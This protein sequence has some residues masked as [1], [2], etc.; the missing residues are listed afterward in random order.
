MLSTSE[1]S[2]QH[3]VGAAGPATELQ[4]F[5]WD[6]GHKTDPDFNGWPDGWVRFTGAGHPRYVKIEISAHDPEF[7]KQVRQLDTGVLDVWTKVRN[8]VDIL[9]SVPPPIL[10]AMVDRYLRIQLDGGQARLTSPQIAAS[11]RYQYRF[12]CRIMTQGLRHDAA[13]A[14][15]VFLDKENREITVHPTPPVSGTKG[16]TEVT[17]D[18]IRPPVGAAKMI[19]RLVVER[20]ENGL[21]D[22]RGVIGFDDIRIDQYPQMR[23]TTD[24]ALGVY[25]YGLPIR[26]TA[27]IMGLPSGRPTVVF[28]VADQHHREITR[29]IIVAEPRRVD[30]ESEHSSTSDFHVNWTLPQLEPGF[31]HMTASI[32]GR[33]ASTLNT[34][35]TIAVIDRN[36]DGPPH[37][38]FGWS[39][40]DGHQ[41]IPPRELAA[42]LANLG[43]AW[44][45]YPCWLDGDDPA[46]MDEVATILGKLRE[47]GIQTIGLLDKPPAK[48]QV[49][50]NTQGR[51]ELLAAQM[52]H[53]VE[54]WKPLLSPV[55]NRLSLKVRTWQ[56]GSDR[57]FSFLETSHLSD[58]IRQIAIGLQGYSQPIDV[59]ISWPWLDRELPDEEASWNA[60][61]RSTDPPLEAHEMDAFL[62]IATKNSGRNGPKIWMMLDPIAEDVYD[63]E[64]RI[65]DLVLRMAT[66]RS[67][68]V[69]AAFVTDPRDP[70][71]G[72]LA[73]DGRPGEML[74]PWRTT[75]RLIG[76][77]RKTGS[78]HLRSDAE[79][80]V[81][82]DS[83]RAV[84]MVWSAEPTEELIYLGDDV[85]EID[86]WGKETKLPLEPHRSQPFQRVKV[87]RTPKF[88]VGADPALL[89]FRMS[90][91]IKEKQLD[92]F[93]GQL[94]ELSVVFRNPANASL[95][96][97][98]RIIAPDTWAIPTPAQSWEAL[99]DR[100]A[101]QMFDVVLSNTAKIG[102]HEL[103]IQFELDTEPPKLFTVYRKVS[104]GP[105]GLELNVS[106][107]LLPTGDL[108]VQ[109][110]MT[111]RSTRPQAYDCML[112]PPNKQHKRQLISVP[113]GKTRRK[114]IKWPNGAEL[115]GQN[116]LFRASELEGNRILNLMVEISP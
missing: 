78:L 20:S 58:A 65:R 82:A 4:S 26:T 48:Q 35:T 38:S 45:K 94:Q 51:K 101:T 102:E 64:S 98:T 77:L 75:S 61:C 63:R 41:G 76:N 39:L 43:V 116:M 90:V 54:T 84:L 87:G 8:T 17:L 93:L 19:V 80:I 46:G 31:Y 25:A 34:S 88:I 30:P 13:R 53:D 49:Q 100:T 96:G 44:V 107:K 70:Q 114:E 50:F 81:F 83:N 36:I 110:E 40:P 85:R 33:R 106:T 12:A 105:E 11:R 69:Q 56:L 52:F 73:A 108:H 95:I 68:P 16:W 57:D 111:N 37:G 112:F 28:R 74:L 86:V 3:T 15:L 5:R 104:V 18:F 2:D 24:Q 92:S 59:A 99:A 91:D 1:A 22:I 71:K 42:W 115:I 32:P 27:T 14:E 103:P 7:E 79:N 113:P 72:L 23:I 66:V 47:A 89:A 55:M 109:I 6:F 21:E 10:D 67:F 60:V 9:P 62:T 29:Q 97:T